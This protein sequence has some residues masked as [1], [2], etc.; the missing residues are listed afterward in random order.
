MFEEEARERQEVTSKNA[1]RDELG[2]LKP[3]AANLHQPGR[4]S[5]ERRLRLA[6]SDVG[7]V[8]SAAIHASPFWL[9]VEV[10]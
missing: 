8:D 5:A 2:H 7:R 6:L 4:A 3:V 9:T 1:P 10:P